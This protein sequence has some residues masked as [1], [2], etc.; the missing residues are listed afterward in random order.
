MEMEMSTK[1][2]VKIWDAINR[3]EKAIEFLKQQI[4]EIK[5]P[6]STNEC[7]AQTY[8]NVIDPEELKVIKRDYMSPSEFE[9]ELNLFSDNF[10]AD[11]CKKCSDISKF[12]IKLPRGWRIM[13]KE[14]IEYV[15]NNHKKANKRAQRFLDNP[16]CMVMLESVMEKKKLQTNKTWNV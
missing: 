13:P 2:F 12:G 1:W 11:V 15:A 4:Q 9:R 14:F 7:K 8:E 16:H 10:I 6:L 5:R 3:N